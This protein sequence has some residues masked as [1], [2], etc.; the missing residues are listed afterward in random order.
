MLKRTGTLCN[1]LKIE[2][3]MFK[4]GIPGNAWGEGLKKRYP[5]IT[6]GK[7]EKLGSN[8]ARALSGPITTSYYDYLESLLDDLNVKDKPECI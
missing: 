6:T 7:P 5:E 1:R 2:T 4:K 3:P 8:R